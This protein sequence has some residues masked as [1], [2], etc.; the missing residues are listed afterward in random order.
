MRID[1]EYTILFFAGDARGNPVPEG[2]GST[3]VVSGMASHPP[4]IFWMGSVSLAA[5]STTS[6]VAA[7]KGL[8]FELRQH[9]HIT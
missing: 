3:I 9:K 7:Y 8:L 2:A 4:S 1:R 6:N 5:A